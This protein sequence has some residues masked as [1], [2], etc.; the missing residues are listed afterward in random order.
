MYDPD[1]R[2]RDAL[3]CSEREDKIAAESAQAA[4]RIFMILDRWMREHAESFY[5]TRA[6]TGGI[7]IALMTPEAGA[8]F[9]YGE[10]LQVAYAQAAQVI[11]FNGGAL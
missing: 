9:F 1:G 6:T 5:L 11:E 7:E 3:E 8:Q 10:S 4:F 2:I